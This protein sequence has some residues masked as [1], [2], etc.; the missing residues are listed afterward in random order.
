MSRGFLLS[1]NAEIDNP[2]RRLPWTLPA[3]LVIWTVAL[4]GLAYFIE[5]P[6][7][8]TAEPPPIDAQLIEQFP[9]A[10]K[11]RPSP[12]H[13]PKPLHVVRPQQAHVMPQISP[14]NEQN[15]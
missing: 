9:A 8:R 11:E 14:R 2:W 7:E 3:A 5:K 13:Q 10:T 15:P 6:T 4:W 12:V 1:R